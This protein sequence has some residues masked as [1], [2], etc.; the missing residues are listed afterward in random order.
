VP[1]AEDKLKEEATALGRARVPGSVKSL[2]Q[3]KTRD[4]M[5]MKT[6]ITEN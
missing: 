4:L 2:V 1:P 5:I 3:F 6:T